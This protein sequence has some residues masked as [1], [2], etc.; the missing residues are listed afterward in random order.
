MGCKNKKSETYK[1]FKTYKVSAKKHQGSVT[2]PK[3]HESNTKIARMK[4]LYAFLAIG[5]ITLSSCRFFGGGERINGDGNIVTVSRP[6]GN[7]SGVDAQGSY[8]IHLSQGPTPSV[9]IEGDQNLMEYVDVFV[10]GNTLVIKSRRGFNLRPSR[11]L[12]VYATAP[13]FREIDISGAC[14]IVSDNQLTGNEQL[15][16]TA[17]GAGSVKLQVAYPKVDAQ[18]SGAGTLELNGQATDFMAEMSGSSEVRCFGLITDQAQL[19]LSGASDVEV[20]ANKKM[21][22]QVSGAGSV[23][24]KGNASVSQKV[25]GAGSVNK[26]G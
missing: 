13:Q 1:V 4:L 5:L 15:T 2:C 12:I 10:E 26:V 23:K 24:Y 11:D 25:S 16:I 9:R 19:D 8:Q 14:D 17:S 7:F 20:T 6:A 21:D 22:V 18:M 3:N